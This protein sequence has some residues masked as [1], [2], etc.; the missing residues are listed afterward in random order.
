MSPQVLKDRLLGVTVYDSL[1]IGEHVMRPLPPL[2]VTARAAAVLRAGA[3][4]HEHRPQPTSP[5][6]P[7]FP[8]L[9]C[10]SPFLPPAPLPP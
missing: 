4:H 3:L 7:P 1:A 6:S 10:S 9:H 5:L 2:L 8:L